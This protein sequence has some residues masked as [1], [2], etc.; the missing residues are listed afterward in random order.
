MNHRV[1]AV[2]LAARSSTFANSEM[3]MRSPP[4]A[5]AAGSGFGTAGGVV[6]DTGVSFSSFVLST[7]GKRGASLPRGVPGSSRPQARSGGPGSRSPRPSMAK[8][9]A[10]ARGITG[11]ARTAESRTPSMS[12]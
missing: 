11:D 7:R 2:I 5:G 8:M 10:A 3:S 4:G 6:S 12:R 9:R 1:A